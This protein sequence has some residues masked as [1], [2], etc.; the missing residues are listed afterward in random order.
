MESPVGLW[1]R[2]RQ[3]IFS[4]TSKSIKAMV[5]I[6]DPEALQEEELIQGIDCLEL[7]EQ[8]RMIGIVTRYMDEYFSTNLSTN[9]ALIRGFSLKS[10]MFVTS[11]EES[12]YR[13]NMDVFYQ[14]ADGQRIYEYLVSLVRFGADEWHV[15][16]VK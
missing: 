12:V 14:D 11:G 7:S 2:L 6:S 9:P 16:Q 15:F 1:S 3:R 10:E 8:L 4:S 5:V 13:S